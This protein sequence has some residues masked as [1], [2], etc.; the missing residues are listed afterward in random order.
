MAL[1]NKVL[2]GFD[3]EEETVNFGTRTIVENNGSLY[4]TSTIA[5]IQS[6]EKAI[7]EPNVLASMQYTRLCVAIDKSIT[8]FTNETCEEILLSISF[9]S[10]IV[11]YCISDDSSFLFVVLSSGILY[12]LHLLTKGQVIFSKN[13]TSDTN[14]IKT[15]LLQNECE[16]INI[17]LVAKNGVIYRASKFNVKLIKDAI[18]NETNITVKELVDQVQYVQLFKG[19]S[20]DEVICATIGIIN[21]EISVAMICSNM[22]FM[23]PSEQCNNFNS[24][25]Y[26][27][28][29]VKFLKNHMSMLCLCTN[30]ILHMVCPQTLLGLKVYHKPVSDFVI[31]ED[32]D[33]SSCQILILTTN[34]SEC[35]TT[36]TL[37]VL[38]FPEFEQ[39]FQISVPITTYLVEIMDPWDEVILFLEGVNYF[40]N[41]TKYIDTIRMKTI[42]ESL[43]EYQLQRLIRREQFDGAEAFA[44]KFNLSLEP[45]YC[46]KA[47]LFLSQLG[48]WARKVTNPIQLDALLNIF[49]KIENVQYIVECCSKAL[50]PDYKQ[51]RKIYLYARTRIMETISKMRNNEHQNLLFLINNT[52]HKLETFHMIWGYC[53]DSEFYNEDTMKEWIRFSR[54]NFMEEYKTHLSLGELDAATLIWT[55]HLPDIVKYISVESM[56][57]IFAILP[58]KISPPTLWPWLSHFIPTLLSFIPGAMGEIILWGCN[59]VKSFEQS[60]RAT[61]P[62]NGI[63]FANKFVKLLRIEESDLTMQSLH[64]HRECLSKGSDLKKF[65]FLMQALS[66]IKKLREK[67]RLTIFLDSYIGEPIEVSYMLLNKVHVDIIPQFV[68]TFLKQYML[69]NSLQND[70]VFSTYIQKT[71]NNFK[72]WWSGEEAPWEQKIVVIIGLI[73]NVETK[74]QQTL[75]VL[76]KASV[77]WSST[78]INLA[79]MSINLDHALASQIR[80]EYNFVPIKLILKKYGY[81]RIGI[82]DKFVCR[83]IKENHDDMISHIEQITKNDPLLRKQAFSSC[84]N[85]YLSRG[86][87]EKVMEILKSLETDILLY[88]C[89][90]IVNYVRASLTLKIIPKSLEHFIEMLGWV[91]LQLQEMAKKSKSQSHYCNS[92]TTSIDE[93]KSMYFLKKEFQIDITVKEYYTGKKQVLQNYIEKLYSVDTEKNDCLPIKYKKVIKVADLLHLQRLEAVSLLLEWTKDVDMFK[94]F[95]KS[96]GPQF[97]LMQEE[98]QYIHKMCSLMLQYAEMDPGIAVNIQ[99]LISTSLCVCSDDELQ[100]MLLLLVWSNLYQ[101]CFNKTTKHRSDEPSTIQKEVSKTNWKLYTIYKDL[102]IAADE[103]LLPLFRD[104]ISLQKFHMVKSKSDI[105]HKVTDETVLNSKPLSIQ[106]P[107]KELLDKMKKLKVEHNDYC[108]L[109]IIKTLYC[110]ISI[111]PDIPPTLLEETQSLYFH[112]LIV[113]IKKILSTRTFDLH[114]GLSCLFML[115]E[116]EACK[117]ISTAC[118][119]L[120]PDCTRHLRISLLGYEYFRLT[121]NQLLIQT[122]Q[123]NKTLHLWAQKLSKYSIS[124]KEIL[125]SDTTTKRE[126]LQHMMNFTSDHMVSLFEE[127]CLNFGFDVQDCLLLYLQTIIKTWNP[128]LNICN[129]NGRKELHIDK[130]EVNVLEKKC[131]IV[132]AKITD[133]AAL[134]NCINSVISQI[135]FYYYEV[136][137]ILMDLIEHKNIE[138]INFFCFLQNYTRNSQPTQTERDEWMHLNPECTNLPP[139][140][141]WRLPFL[142]KVAL[143]TLITPE[144][145]LKSYEKWLEIAPVLKLQSHIICTLAIKGEVTHTWGNKYKTDKWSLCLRNSSLLNNIKRCIERMDGPNA[146]YYGTAA[147]YYVV[148][149]T[150]PGADQVAAVEE[151]YKY[152]QLSVQKSTTFE[153]GML[154][155]I[156]FKYLRFTSEH[157]LRTHGLEKRNYLSLIGNPY[158]LVRELYTDESI[159]QRYRCVIDHRPDINSAVNSLSQL[160]SINMM[161]LWLELLQ[162]W[163]QPENK[164]MKFNQSIT[165]TFSVV[166]S[167]P[168]SNSDDNLLRARYILEYRNLELSANF[169]INIAFNDSNENY[170]PETRY[171]A[172]HVLQSI[173]NTAELED[174]T[175]RNNQTIKKYMKSLKYIDR[176]ESLGIGYSINAFETCSKHELV[177]ILWKTQSYSTQALILIAQICIDFEV[178]DYVLW[179][180]NLTQLA[181]LLIIN[182]LKKILLQVRNICAIVNCNGYISGWQVVISEPFR[183]M[184]IH[185]TF[186][187]I[188]NCIEALH[189]LYSCPVVHALCF[190]DIMKYCFHCQ[191]PHIA[192]AFL[193]FLDDDVKEYVLQEIKDTGNVNKVLEDLSNLSLNG[194]L[195]ISYCIKV[196]QNTLLKTN[197]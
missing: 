70:Y 81:E 115:P 130:D 40:E 150:P 123:D 26:N 85:Y 13:I 194:I 114:L 190:N 80:I 131:N 136:F 49:D 88:C 120:P 63:D 65:V 8:I 33:N 102:A 119:S 183:K 52:L 132:A 6:N 155:K 163:L 68:N 100:S 148:N 45:I 124:Y 116:S 64:A 56:Q 118:K 42:S 28:S 71:I 58:E 138:H 91:K 54:A 176:L 82:N 177:Q 188:N 186:E 165:D 17:Y 178:H 140:A 179:D 1:W 160:F 62:Q 106:E 168:N 18:F 117:W 135:N 2:S 7:N 67:Y 103:L 126:I 133:K 4:E 105:E 121:K 146:L 122:Y 22:L 175:K 24:V 142:P 127:F 96:K 147:L 92:V 86:N 50:I 44:N 197:M 153:E 57:N 72:N 164:Y 48:P 73:Q 181:K 12:C 95:S 36:R 74:L 93:V 166:N 87:F 149:H 84:T 157:I 111:I 101:D 98:C 66:D 25:C 192:A 112:F 99:N 154:E 97:H 94:Y 134:V 41:N 128:K 141:E 30:N 16:F 5:T 196:I 161:K 77:P 184:D 129:V 89:V 107:L 195:C 143:W 21:E 104:V 145:N 35:A 113:L 32:N 172:L 158:K 19:F 75:D 39:K 90:Q 182:E 59:R 83:I 156:K 171:R 137:I 169:L 167:E 180:K 109:Q 173:F 69:N 23:W 193:P 29:M 61:W 31:I 152:A 55:R 144:L 151:C 43:P 60:H 38:S 108:L 185:P 15:I 110:N 191:Q 125:T 170:S 189:L 3:K 47:A 14:T 174:L 46:A 27:Y 10:L 76:K 34:D 37:C 187:Q 162:E 51:M 78:M 159:P 20:H 9:N 79:E 53:K 11:C 139:I